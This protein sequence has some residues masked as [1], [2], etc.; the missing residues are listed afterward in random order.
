MIVV[1]FDLADVVMLVTVVQCKLCPTAAYMVM[2]GYVMAIGECGCE[3]KSYAVLPLHASVH[4]AGRTCFAMVSKDCFSLSASWLQ[5]L[6]GAGDM[7][8]N[9]LASS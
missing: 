4:W 6:R 9:M 1:I 3:G 5:N 7:C 2:V 8:T